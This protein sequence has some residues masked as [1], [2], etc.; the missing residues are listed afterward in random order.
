MPSGLSETGF[1]RK[2]LDELLTELNAEM[3]SIFGEN[4]NL[5]PQ[6]PDGQVNGVMAESQANLWEK[7]EQ[8]YNSFNP[9]SA[10]GDSLSNVVQFNHITRKAATFSNVAINVTGTN[11]T[12][13]TAGSLVS[14]SDTEAQFSVDADITIVLGVGSGTATAVNAGEINSFAGTVTVIDTPIFGWDTVTNPL[15][16]IPGENEETDA[17]LRARRNRST[18]TGSISQIDSLVGAILNIVDV[19]DAIVYENSS[20]LTD[21]NGVPP[22]SIAA[23]VDG[24]GDTEIAQAIFIK[25]SAGIGSFGPVVIPI[26]D[27]QGIIQNINFSRPTLIDIY[28]DIVLTPLAG[29]PGNGDDL[30]KQAIVNYANGL[31]IEG[32]GFSISDDV[33]YS[34]LYIPI[35]SVSGVQVDSLLIGIA[36]APAL[37][38]NIVITDFQLSVF[39]TTR[40]NIA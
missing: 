17:E 3:Q 20:T 14:T 2:R 9:N 16:G 15:D 13:I 19:E 5:E 1:E 25:K 11:G 6:S 4:L 18:S 29:Y 12:I 21:P 30:I 7:L 36:P 39:D 31:L 23:V 22:H 27:S 24:G 8:V 34:E 35:N 33:I 40:I 32:R 37:T 26:T 38:T 10:T 28:I